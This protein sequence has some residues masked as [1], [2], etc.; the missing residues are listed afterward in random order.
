[1]E[2]NSRTFTTFVSMNV[3]IN[4]SR[5]KYLLSLYR[6]E[7]VDLLKIINDGRKRIIPASKVFTNVI[8]ISILKK[9][10]AIFDK[11][12]T[13]YVDPTPI[14]PIGSM[15]VFFRKQTF[16]QELNF[17]SKK[18]V[19]DYE[20]LKDY[21]TSLDTL[22]NVRT[23]VAIPHRTQRTDPRA[24]A[25]R[26]RSLIYPKEKCKTP[27][28]FLKALI[29]NLAEAGVLVFE[30]IEA[31]NKK[32]KANIDGFFLKPNFIVLK[33]Y[34][35]YQREI[36]TLLHELG[37]CVLNIEEIESLNPIELNYNS[38]SA[39]ERWC[40]DFAYYFLMGSEADRINAITH[41][42][43]TNDYQFPLIEELSTKCFISK[44]ALFTRLYY[45]GRM[46]TP[47]YNNVVRDLNY[48]AEQFLERQKA[49]LQTT[50]EEGRRKTIALPQPIYSPKFLQTLS[51]A[52][53][54]GIVRPSDLYRM[55]IPAR[56]VEGLPKWL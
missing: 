48:R 55:N 32:E 10:D 1:M 19:N 3:E 21:L 38:M 15:S 42:D 29:G 36:F 33:R 27:R 49:K 18:L 22:S 23:K 13:F 39:I 50:D 17:T 56:V 54:D 11:G 7:E 16:G 9:I 14:S 51:V 31:P 44:R 6:M 8:D 20:S 4:I 30:F 40:N 5:L 37:H 25:T 24:A 12:L 34:S 2:E 43:G 45:S 41:A 26:V 28:D 53:N 35:Y 46:T 52:L 47:D